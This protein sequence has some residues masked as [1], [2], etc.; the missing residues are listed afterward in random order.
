MIERSCHDR[1]A[2]TERDPLRADQRRHRFR[3]V[4]WRTIRNR[5]NDRGIG[6][7]A[8]ARQLCQINRSTIVNLAYARELLPWS[9]G[10]WKVKLSNNVE[11]EVSRGSA[12]GLK[13]RIG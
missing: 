1:A 11:L 5:P 2:L 4:A 9:L 3:T 8:R 13:S 7:T 6:R 12:R 10:T